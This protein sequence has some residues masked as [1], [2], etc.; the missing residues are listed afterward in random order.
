MKKRTEKNTAKRKGIF[1]KLGMTY[2]ELICALALLSLIVVMFTPMLLS[3]YEQLYNAGEK[4]SEIYDDKKKIEEGLA[5]RDSALS[6]NFSM[7]LMGVNADILFENINVMGR[8]I[9]S[10]SETVFET[11]FG[12]LRPSLTLISPSHV[13][14]DSTSHEILIQTRGLEFTEVKD[15][16]FSDNYDINPKNANRKLPEKTIFIEVVIPDKT[17]GGGGNL[18]SGESAST[19]EL[20]VYN[21]EGGYCAVDVI[22]ATTNTTSSSTGLGSSS[23]SNLTDDGKLFLKISNSKLDFTYSPLKLNVYYVNTRGKTRLISEYIYIDPPTI[24]MAGETTESDYYTSAGVKEITDEKTSD[25]TDDPERISKYVLQTEARK[26]RTNNSNYLTQQS[27]I[28]KN[29]TG[30]PSALGVEINSIRWIDNDE[31]AGLA[32]YYVMT[33]SDGMIYRMYNYTSDSTNIYKYSQA[34]AMK[35]AATSYYG[36]T[37]YGYIDKIYNISNGARIYPSLWSGDF[38]HVFEYTSA[39]K[40]VAY[41]ESANNDCDETWVTSEKR[42]GKKGDDQLFNVFSP[43]VE[44]AYCYNGSGT[45]HEFRY[46]NARPISYILTEK[47]WPLRLFGVINDDKKDGYEDL[48]A[49]WDLDNTTEAYRDS[50]LFDDSS[51][52]LAFRYPSANSD[53]QN[54]YVYGAIR[55]K[56]IASYDMSGLSDL[57]NYWNTDEDDESP[58]YESKLGTVRRQHNPKGGTDDKLNGDGS[59]INVTDVIYIPSTDDG[60]TGSTFYVGNVHAYANILQTNKIESGAANHRTKHTE[61][62]GPWYARRHVDP[63]EEADMVGRYYRNAGDG[64]D[65]THLAGNGSSYPK[66]AVT[67]YIVASNNSTDGTYVCKFNDND[68]A[69]GYDSERQSQFTDV[70][71]PYINSVTNEDYT[72]TYVQ[73]GRTLEN[74][75]AFFLPTIRSSPQWEYIYLEDVRFT[76][77]YAS[78]RERVYTYIT[79]DG[80]TGTEFIRSFERLYWRSHY[81][82]DLAKDANLQKAFYGDLLEKH[83]QNRAVSNGSGGLQ[84]NQAHL[85][86]VSNDYYNVWFPGEMYN[87]S[88]IATKDGVTVAVGYA[89]VGSTYQYVHSAE[90]TSVTSTGL[91]G[92][93][94]DGV[95]SA[96]IEGQ[97]SAFVNLLYYKDNISFDKSSLYTEDPKNKDSL[98]LAQYAEYGEYGMHTR[99]SINF[100]AVDIFV[101]DIPS[102]TGST[103]LNYWAIY[104]DNKGRVFKSLVATGTATSTGSGDPD[105]ENSSVVVTKNIQL[106]NYISDNIVLDSASASR[107]TIANMIEINI[108]GETGTLDHYFSRI[109]SIEAKDDMIIITGENKAVSGT[110][111]YEAIVV[112]IRNAD[113]TW[114]WK[115]LQN[116]TFTG[117]I[118]D[119][120]I[121]NGYYYFIGNDPSAKKP[122]IG[123]V[124]LDALKT[125]SV[126]LTASKEAGKSDSKNEVIWAY[127]SNSDIKLNTIAGRATS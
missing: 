34:T 11:V 6:V 97:D 55:I 23:V 24:M 29:S 60:T 125:A 107:S 25:A 20:A 14:D 124:S 42:Q 77:G 109:S 110:T 36:G 33:G 52:V 71:M 101:E 31:T 87:L 21:G 5:R 26:M 91:G 7:N 58:I 27:A 53:M 50:H 111:T 106:V 121:L 57:V 75:T 114:T 15:G 39:E 16:K 8:K 54:D 105:D 37:T 64:V 113:G 84:K 99:D 44:Y 62:V 48:V 102:N 92:I 90:D 83:S 78:N 85:N 61:W 10:E 89:V 76:F 100:T 86:A 122:F 13:N 79:Y 59:E 117:N 120:A 108:G 12:Q 3:S 46:K 74:R 72:A 67:D 115:K 63:I 80:E 116:D 1:N 56:A 49:L 41:G 104:G 88:K 17:K 4:I 126:K 38:S 96:M 70:I 65:N 94:N 43:Q 69:R 2:I 103:T 98:K 73:D 66:G 123:A 30:S 40:R 22:T 45:N 68:Y 93:Y 32:P 118:T 19:E 28:R 9:V 51:E 18:D 47:G 127:V 95:L 81:G 35:N 119:A 82:Q 112:G